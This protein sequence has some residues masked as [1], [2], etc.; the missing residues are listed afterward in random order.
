LGGAEEGVHRP[1]RVGRDQ[2]HRAGGRL[3]EIGGGGD[4]LD[5]GRVEVVPVEFAE[6]VGRDLADEAGAAAERGD[7]GGGVA[8]R[9][10]A[11]LAR[12]AHMI[13]EPRRLRRV[14]QPHHPLG[15]PL[16][17]E[18]IVIAIGDDVDDRIADREHVEAG[19]GHQ[20]LRG[21][22]A[23][24]LEH[25]RAGRQRPTAGKMRRT[26]LSGREGPQWRERVA[27]DRGLGRALSFLPVA[28]GGEEGDRTECGGGESGAARPSTSLRLVP[29][30][31]ASPTGRMSGRSQTWPLAR[32]RA[33]AERPSAAIYASGHPSN[34]QPS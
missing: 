33:L 10:A 20:S 32:G 34:E 14:D 8:R 28:A 1:V 2:H 27:L 11:D 5:A 6:L 4:E 17:R 22:K 24:D 29:S 3:A 7:A 18:E 9:A 12:R 21:G 30:P 31:S 23:R 19:F 13:V 16:A 15:Q 26:G 25:F